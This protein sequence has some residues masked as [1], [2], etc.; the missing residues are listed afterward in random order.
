MN[1]LK[2]CAATIAISM[3]FTVADPISTSA[4][5]II[6]LD[7][8]VSDA[9]SC[10]LIL[11][12]FNW[13]C[14]EFETPGWEHIYGSEFW[15]RGTLDVAR[16]DIDIDSI[17]DLVIRINHVGYCGTAGCRHQFLF[18]SEPQPGKSHSYGIISRADHIYLEIQHGEI[19]VKF[20]ENGKF[21]SI[22]KLKED[23]MNSPEIGLE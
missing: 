16:I 9:A 5:I 10:N 14:A 11:A 6:P 4:D 18:G 1:I 19:G 7:Q 8:H 2:K 22:T 13:F 21:F 20:Y 15:T 17:D 23:T 3:S 12:E